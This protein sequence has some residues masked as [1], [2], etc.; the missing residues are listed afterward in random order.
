MSKHGNMS[1]QEVSTQE[2]MGCS[3]LGKGH[4]ETQGLSLNFRNKKGS[5][6]WSPEKITTPK[7]VNFSEISPDVFL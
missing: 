1:K 5:F 6:I 3:S 2:N 4:A 7:T